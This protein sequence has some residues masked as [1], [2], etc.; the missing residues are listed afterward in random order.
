MLNSV[1]DPRWEVHDNG[2]PPLYWWENINQ[3]HMKLNLIRRSNRPDMISKLNNR[4]KYGYIW[5]INH[6]CDRNILFIQIIMLVT[7]LQSTRRIPGALIWP[8]GWIRQPMVQT[9]KSIYF[10]SIDSDGVWSPLL[11]IPDTGASDW[12]WLSHQ[13]SSPSV[14]VHDQRACIMRCGDGEPIWVREHSCLSCGFECDRDLNAAVNILQRDFSELGLGWTEPTSSER[15]SLSWS[16]KSSVFERPVETAL[17]M[18]TTC[19]SEK[20]VVETRSL[21]AWPPR[22]FTWIS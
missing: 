4:I 9:S 15:S 5:V 11:C 1:Q 14:Q 16:R 21:G 6:K 3:R 22:R 2:E 18:D 12:T 19:V 8:R 17:P 7:I 10:S 20:R 13:H